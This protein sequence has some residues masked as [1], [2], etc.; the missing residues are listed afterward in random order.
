MTVPGAL[1]DNFCADTSLNPFVWQTKSDVLSEL[2]SMYSSHVLPA[3]AFSSSGLQMSGPGAHGQFTGIQSAESFVAPFNFSVTV[4]GLEPGSIPFEIYLVNADLKQ[5]LTITGHLGGG[6]GS[7]AEIDF[8]TGVRPA[9]G[10]IRVGTSAGYGLWINHTG[11]GIPISALGSRFTT[12]P[13]TASPPDTSPGL[14]GP[15][16]QRLR[17]VAGLR[18]PP[19]R[20]AE[21]RGR[22]RAI[23][24][25]ARS[26]QQR[27]ARKMAIRPVDSGIR[28]P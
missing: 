16:W 21:R 3:L 15:G 8:A 5:R 12:I 7:R 1:Q 4:S 13:L 25:R 17:I 2:A 19:A 22:N 9:D 11:S 28:R 27:R 23:L 10:G 24:R 18:R 20:H 26:T 14:R 6:G